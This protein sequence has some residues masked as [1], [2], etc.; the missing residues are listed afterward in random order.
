M[1]DTVCQICRKHPSSIVAGVISLIIQTAF[2][3]WFSL[4]VVGAYQTWYST[5][6]NNA[7]LNLAMVF[8]VF[9][10]YWTSQV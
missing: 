7:R 3:I 6:S 10:Y 5:T 2:S 9:S 4:V 1:L 8:I